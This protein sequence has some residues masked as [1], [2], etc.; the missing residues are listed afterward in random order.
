[1]AGVTGQALRIL[2][3]TNMY[4]FEGKPFYGSFVKDEVDA[5]VAAGCEVDVL[6]INGLESKLNYFASPLRLRRQ[7]RRRAYDIVHVHHTFCGLVAT[8]QREI[9]VVWTFHEGEILADETI[10]R[11]DRP[12]KRFTY[13]VGLKRW[14]AGR[15]GALIVVSDH[16]RQELGRPD[17]VTIPAG[18]DL[19]LFAPMDKRAARTSLGLSADARYV[20]FPSSPERL[21]KR[22]DLAT[23][24]VDGLRAT[25]GDVQLLALDDVPHEKVPFYMN[26]SDV[27]L[28]TSSFEAS[29]V[30]VREALACNLP[31]VSTDV[32]DV[33]SLLAGVEGCHVVGE[34]PDQIASALVD[35][36]VGR[37]PIEGRGIVADHALD[38]IAQKIVGVYRSL[39]DRQPAAGN[40]RK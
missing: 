23:R 39:I 33:R 17:A 25:L 34:D 26:A 32:G 27:L 1:M 14:V 18:L 3:F 8:W 28:M 20:L 35:V 29:P 10:R 38:R 30:T 13:W 40:Q 7:L 11:V 22:Y 16:L 9:P 21:E 12:V 5:L 24:S 36:L 4:P 6:F 37:R 2:V 15:V 31:V 19:N